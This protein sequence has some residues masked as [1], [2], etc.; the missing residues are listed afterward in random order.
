MFFSS[1]ELK[2]AL[3][4]LKIKEFRGLI[5]IF[6]FLGIAIGIAALVVTTSVMNGFRDELIS[7]VTKADGHINIINT[8]L[9]R[10][11]LKDRLSHINDIEGIKGIALQLQ[12]QSMASFGGKVFGVIVKGVCQKDIIAEDLITNAI[13]QGDINLTENGIIIGQKIAERF[14]IKVGDKLRL[15]SGDGFFSIGGFL[16]RI[17]TLEV[18]GVFDSG[19]EEYDTFFVYVPFD[20]ASKLFGTEQKPNVINVYIKNIDDTQRIKSQIQKILD[21]KVTDWQQ[22][23]GPY[24]SA[25]KIEKNGNSKDLNNG[26]YCRSR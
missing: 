18:V 5:A 8:D 9:S 4:Y 12:F 10:E 14:D 7:H 25:L 3:A 19:V 21:L 11:E 15:I 24:Q 13:K 1:I 26:K 22:K 17:K 16:P 6:A 2:I 23:Q 20:I